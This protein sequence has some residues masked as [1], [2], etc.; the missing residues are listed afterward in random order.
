MGHRSLAS[1]QQVALL[2]AIYSSHALALS[3]YIYALLLDYGSLNFN[4]MIIY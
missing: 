1:I 3:Q 2:H 4:G